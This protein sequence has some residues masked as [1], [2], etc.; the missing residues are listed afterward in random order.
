MG[1]SPAAWQRQQYF[2]TVLKPHNCWN[3]FVNDTA[4]HLSLGAICPVFFYFE[5]E[6]DYLDI[7]RDHENCLS[8]GGFVILESLKGSCYWIIVLTQSEKN[9]LDIDLRKSCF[10]L[11]LNLIDIRFVFFTIMEILAPILLVNI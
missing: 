7:W 5:F 10:L 1:F 9:T 6:R 2:Y 11:F 3:K 8:C 4:V